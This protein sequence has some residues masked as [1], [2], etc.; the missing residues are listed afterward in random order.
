MTFPSETTYP[1]YTQIDGCTVEPIQVGDRTLLPACLGGVCTDGCVRLA[2]CTEIA[3][4]DGGNKAI[5]EKLAVL[6]GGEI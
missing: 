3:W 1:Q 2:Q 6:H 5:E 4:S